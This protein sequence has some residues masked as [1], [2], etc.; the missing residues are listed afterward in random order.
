MIENKKA[1]DILMNDCKTNCLFSKIYVLQGERGLGQLSVLRKFRDFIENLDP[2]VAVLNI[3]ES[4]HGFPL[5][6][7]WK[8]M[9]KYTEMEYSIEPSDDFAL[10]NNGLDYDEYLISRIISLSHEMRMFFICENIAECGADLLNFIRKIAAN[11]IKDKQVNLIC[12]YYK[13]DFIDGMSPIEYFASLENQ[14]KYITFEPWSA[15]ELEAFMMGYFQNNIKFIDVN[16]M[17]IIT[18]AYGNPTQLLNIIEY[19]KSEEIIFEEGDI[20]KCTSLNKDLLLDQTEAYVKKIYES[21]DSKMQRLLRSSSTIGYEFNKHL[22]THPLNILKSYHNLN[23]LEKVTRLIYEKTEDIFA[24]NDEASFLS[25]KSVVKND[26]YVSWNIELADFF[27]QEGLKEKRVGN[28]TSVLETWLKSGYYYAKAGMNEKTFHIYLQLM[29]M[30]LS[31]MQYSKTLDVIQAL[32]D[33]G[34]ELM[35]DDISKRLLMVEGDCFYSLFQ[36]EKAAN[37]YKKLLRIC[38][39]DASEFHTIQCKYA[40]SLY[41]SG[42]TTQA[43]EILRQ[44]HDNV[45]KNGVKGNEKVLVNVLSCMSSIEETLYNGKH[46]DNFNKALDI[47]KKSNLETEYYVLLRKALIVHKGKNGLAL[48]SAARDYYL[49]INNNKEYAMCL[50]NMATEMLYCDDIEKASEYFQQSCKV[51][52]H[53]GSDGFHYPMNGIGLYWCLKGEFDKAIEC[54]NEAYSEN[55]EL[56]SRIS[57]LNNKTSALI[58]SKRYEEAK[59]TLKKTKKL[60]KEEDACNYAIIKQHCILCEAIYERYIGTYENALHSFKKY[61]NAETKNDSH[62]LAIAA[63]CLYELCEERN[64]VFPSEYCE[65]LR[66]ASEAISRLSKH[67]LVLVRFSFAE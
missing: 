18:P 6:N 40:F 8:N 3:K 62:R 53:F 61:F 56:F 4:I 13:G 54:F 15:S 17:D 60:L 65:Y 59:I 28:E 55:Y 37:S 41:N 66:W 22:L 25:I 63:K 5:M 67:N 50:H 64:E 45:I 24:F 31:I 20:Y 57:I 11:V 9:K 19:L 46:E 58:A 29:P 14:T 32:R 35:A 43:Y 38:Q 34:K 52:K 10:A 36:Y 2:K 26:E 30:L 39:T 1:L 7:L 48:M 47:A 42:K 27:Y 44:I 23:K 21:L 51:F 49:K 12:C 16:P 33:I